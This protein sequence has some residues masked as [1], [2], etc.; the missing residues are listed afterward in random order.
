MKNVYALLVLAV[1]AAAPGFGQESRATIGGTVTDQTGAVLPGAV[2]QVRNEATNVITKSATNDHGVYLVPA[3]NPGMY[4]LTATAGGFKNLV[5]NNVE[6]RV[7]DR[8][9]LDLELQ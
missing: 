1:L 8:L 9:N 2:I 3:L 5:R 7:G 6:L 4:S